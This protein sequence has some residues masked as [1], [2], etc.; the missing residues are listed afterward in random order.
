[1][2]PFS[3]AVPPRFTGKCRFDVIRV[4][5]CAGGAN[6][7]GWTLL[8]SPPKLWFHFNSSLA[9]LVNGGLKAFPETVLEGSKLL[10]GDVVSGCFAGNSAADSWWQAT[11][12]GGNYLPALF[13]GYQLGQNDA[14]SAI[15]SLFANTEGLVDLVDWGSIGDVMQDL[16]LTGGKAGQ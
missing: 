8:S 3:R 6:K 16:G 2:L 12:C 5:T 13:I 9:C 14:E 7:K 1:M 11:L 4:F 15:Y 10:P